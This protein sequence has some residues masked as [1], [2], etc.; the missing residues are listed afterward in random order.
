MAGT[1]ILGEAVT[2]FTADLGGLFGRLDTVVKKLDDLSK[3][4]F[5]VKITADA[6]GIGKSIK[7]I[8]TNIQKLANVITRAQQ[9]VVSGTRNTA[10]TIDSILAGSGNKQLRTVQ[11]V[12]AGINQASDN[13]LSRFVSSAAAASF[14]FIST[15]LRTAAVI[16]TIGYAF[17]SK[18][19]NTITRTMNTAIGNVATVAIDNFSKAVS[20]VWNF[21]DPFERLSEIWNLLSPL[22]SRFAD[23][24]SNA[25]RITL[26]F[27][28]N[29]ALAASHARS[30]GAHLSK[31]VQAR[32][33]LGGVGSDALK[34]AAALERVRQT[35]I[36]LNIA[37][38]A[39]V[40]SAV[41]AGT[42][43]AELSKITLGLYAASEKAA[44]AAGKA[45]EMM[46]LARASGTAQDMAAALQASQEAASA[47]RESF[48]A[49]NQ[50]ATKLATSTVS[51]A[52]RATAFTSIAL[53]L[54]G[55]AS[56]VTFGISA[57]K[58]FM[59]QRANTTLGKTVA[60]IDALF[61]GVFRLIPPLA[62]VLNKISGF[63]SL[64]SGLVLLTTS[65]V[66]SV[67]SVGM[68]FGGAASI[69]TGLL[70]LIQNFSV[71]I[72]L[73]FF[74]VA[75]GFGSGRAQFILF[76]N[77]VRESFSF[78]GR[79]V[80]TLKKLPRNLS[81]A[82]IFKNIYGFVSNIQ[83]RLE[84]IVV[85]LG[86]A[87]GIAQDSAQIT[88]V[89][90]K[91]AVASGKSLREIV[92]VLASANDYLSLFAGAMQRTVVY[93]S[94]QVA[95]AIGNFIT[96][97]FRMAGRL[98]M[99]AGRSIV[100]TFVVRFK[101]AGMGLLKWMQGSLFG[102]ILGTVGAVFRT[103]FAALFSRGA[104]FGKKFSSIWDRQRAVGAGVKAGEEQQ[105]IQKMRSASLQINEL[106]RVR[107]GLLDQEIEKIKNPLLEAQAKVAAAEKEVNS[108]L[109]KGQATRKASIEAAQIAETKAGEA[110][111][112]AEKRRDAAQ[113][114]MTSFEAR[115][116]SSS[117]SKLGNLQL[118]FSESAKGAPAVVDKYMRALSEALASSK[119][120]K[121]KSI[122]IMGT[123]EKA[124][125]TVEQQA[126]LYKQALVDYKSHYDAML[127][128]TN[129]SDREAQ[130][131]KAE[132]ALKHIDEQRVQVQK[133]VFEY[134]SAYIE[135]HKKVDLSD[136]SDRKKAADEALAQIKIKTQSAL[137]S[138][139]DINKATVGSRKDPSM[140]QQAEIKRLAEADI[141]AQK[142][143]VVAKREY[144]DQQ[145]QVVDAW[146]K[147]RD[148]AQAT[149]DVEKKGLE[150]LTKLAAANKAQRDQQ[151]LQLE[152]QK[153]DLTALAQMQ[154]A[155]LKAE[156][157][158]RA[159]VIAE[160]A[161]ELNAL[162]EK[163]TKL[164]GLTVLTTK[165]LSVM[166]Q[167][168]NVASKGMDFEK[169]ITGVG[170]LQS[171]VSDAG[172]AA[173]HLV[174][175]TKDGTI[176][177]VKSIDDALTSLVNKN[178]DFFGARSG[179]KKPLF[180]EYM[181]TAD[182][183]A[184]MGILA[185]SKTTLAGVWE[186]LRRFND[187]AVAIRGIG[188]AFNSDEAIAFSR[189]LEGIPKVMSQVVGSTK[190]FIEQQAE[191]NP[192]SAFAKMASSWNSA[193]KEMRKQ[194][195][196]RA[197]PEALAGTLTPDKVAGWIKDYVKVAGKAFSDPESVTILS[198][199]IVSLI[200]NTF[201]PFLQANSP[202][203]KGPLAKIDEWGYKIGETYTTGTLVGLAT[204][205]EK[206]RTGAGKIAQALAPAQ[207][208]F[209]KMFGL[210]RA[211]RFVGGVE[212]FLDG[213]EHLLR[214]R[215]NTFIKAVAQ[216]FGKEFLDQVK[217]MG[218]KVVQG[219]KWLDKLTGG[220]LKKMAKDWGVA[221]FGIVQVF[222]GL[223]QIVGGLNDV[224]KGIA[225]V[226]DLLIGIVTLDWKRFVGG[227][228]GVLQI[229]P[230]VMKLVIGLS[231]VVIGAG[232]AFFGAAKAVTFWAFRLGKVGLKA[233]ILFAAGLLER[234]PAALRSF[235]D[236][237][238]QVGKSVLFL[239]KVGLKAG[240]L[241]AA[242]LLRGFS[243]VA[244]AFGDVFAAIGKGV[245]FL[246]ERIGRA[247]VAIGHGA[248]V[249]A[250]KIGHG[251]G[252]AFALLKRGVVGVAKGLWTG[253][254]K[255]VGSLFGS[256]KE[257][258]RQE[259]AR[260]AAARFA[261]ASEV[262][263][264]VAQAR[265]V[266]SV[267][268]A[269]KLKDNMDAVVVAMRRIPAAGA[270]MKNVLKQLGSVPVLKQFG[271]LHATLQTAVTKSGPALQQ[272]VFNVYK[273]AFG[274]SALLSAT[275]DMSTAGEN[276]S[277]MLLLGLR[278]GKPEAR[279]AMTELVQV[280]ADHLP[281]S[282]PLIGPLAGMMLT[283]S[284]GRIVNMIAD[285][286]ARQGGFLNKVVKGVLYA[287]FFP[288]F[289]GAGI[290][291]GGVKMAIGLISSFGSA[292]RNVFNNELVRMV[293]QTADAMFD[294]A[295]SASRI[296][297]AVAKYDMF[298][299]AARTVG[300]EGTSLYT[301]FNT[302]QRNMAD[303]ASGALD[304]QAK[305][306]RYGVNV[307]AYKNG[308]LDLV[309]TFMALSQAAKDNGDNQVFMQEAMELTGASYGN[310]QALFRLGGN[311]IREA[312]DQMGLVSNALDDEAVRKAEEFR[313]NTARITEAWEGVKREI[314]NVVMPALNKFFEKAL[315]WWASFKDE[316][317][318]AVGLVWQIIEILFTAIFEKLGQWLASSSQATNDLI[319]MLEVLFRSGLRLTQVVF[320]EI[321]K[322][323][324]VLLSSLSD[325]LA[326]WLR[327]LWQRLTQVWFRQLYAW[328]MQTASD[329]AGEFF[330]GVT[331]RIRFW[332]QNAQFDMDR[333]WVYIKSGIYGVIDTLMLLTAPITKVLEWM[334]LI[335]DGGTSLS[336]APEFDSGF[337]LRQITSD[338]LNSA[339]YD[340][341]FRRI[342]GSYARHAQ[343]TIDELEENAA[344][345]VTVLDREYGEAMDHIV[346]N[347]QRVMTEVGDAVGDAAGVII[348]EIGTTLR[349][350]G[351][352]IG[353]NIDY[354][355]ISASMARLRE[356]IFQAVSFAD[357][358]LAVHTLEEL[359]ERYDAL[360]EEMESYAGQ[361]SRFT[362]MFLDINNRIREMRTSVNDLLGRDTFNV[363]G[364][365]SDLASRVAEVRQKITAMTDEADQLAS[366]A[367]R[368]RSET[369]APFDVKHTVVRAQA[370]GFIAEQKLL[371]S[372]KR[373]ELALAERE[374]RL[375]S[376]LIEQQRE[377]Y[378]AQLASRKAFEEEQATALERTLSGMEAEALAARNAAVAGELEYQEQMLARYGQTPGFLPP[379]WQEQ[380][381]TMLRENLEAMTAEAQA[382]RDEVARQA[383][384]GTAQFVEGWFTPALDVLHEQITA[385]EQLVQL[386]WTRLGEIAVI[387]EETAEATRGLTAT[388]ANAQA[389]RARYFA[390]AQAEALLLQNKADAVKAA[391]AAM[392]S[393]LDRVEV[394]S[395]EMALAENVVRLFGSVE[396]PAKD[397][398]QRYMDALGRS[399]D[400]EM[401]TANLR[402][403]FANA[404]GDPATLS[405]IVDRL[406]PILQTFAAEVGEGW[407]EGII[408]GLRRGETAS[409]E[410]FVSW[411]ARFLA[412]ARQ[413]QQEVEVRESQ[414]RIL[415]SRAEDV[416]QRLEV[417][418]S[419]TGTPDF[420]LMQR[421]H[422][423]S[424]LTEINRLRRES[425][426]IQIEQAEADI[427][428][429]F[430]KYRDALSAKI[431][432]FNASLKELTARPL[433]P[434]NEKAIIE[435]EAKIATLQSELD[436]LDG[437]EI[438][439]KREIAIKI[440]Y[441]ADNELRESWLE[442]AGAISN[443]TGEALK[444]G[445]EIAWTGENKL[446]GLTK[447]F[448]TALRDSL[449][450]NFI[451]NLTQT[452]ETQLTKAFASIFK[453]ADSMW[454]QIATLGLTLVTTL[455]VGADEAIEA[456]RD[457]VEDL[458]ESSEQVRG[459]I[460]GDTTVA[461]KEVGDNLRDALQ[462]TNG[463]L[464]DIR[465]GVYAM[466][467]QRGV[468][469]AAAGAST[470]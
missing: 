197:I 220:L 464:R 347:A 60:L 142:R 105:N 125:A 91:A 379:D 129:V 420:T 399:I 144:I 334:G 78:V 203:K 28:N 215:Y 321:L 13:V 393:S 242:G 350:L 459:V 410:E 290:L 71:K 434:E 365:L 9:D 70:P 415:E 462:P 465:D 92:P 149:R 317:Y 103:G 448:G 265:M 411:Y 340:Q 344:Q 86:R 467:R 222:K 346:N 165:T 460:S 173:L 282:P 263:A 140:V 189:V 295:I 442:F 141:A 396:G 305:M 228:R 80:E 51:F 83:T 272:A 5:S 244:R 397:F 158:T 401:N 166:A 94:T 151:V 191:A 440:R 378:S 155:V 336:V 382:A 106:L 224:R 186:N 223:G 100:N 69:L 329:N 351:A 337:A 20:S 48:A 377:E 456:S 438:T 357:S 163:G 395:K 284:G 443:A 250:K 375:R 414:R 318:E 406:Q 287:A 148:A 162:T 79:L 266:A 259:A 294:V 193:S 273:R 345:A 384:E 267:A 286:V 298:A 451:N 179:P 463:I 207:E 301:V 214:G 26:G 470:V 225:S 449:T 188:K 146:T 248:V 117:L 75:A 8:D 325:L 43:L 419:P 64:G 96:L 280:L 253:A 289:G 97:P 116:K 453:S 458:V 98:A 363:S 269:K 53:A 277:K 11:K 240:S 123:V 160:E 182:I 435:L 323:G 268:A 233:G 436:I 409:I 241:F 194:V 164:K 195:L 327:N 73:L 313:V 322:L 196:G 10:K 332:I 84:E 81:I 169:I 425:A 199:H 52:A 389:A 270:P 430:D 312:M 302:L 99:N 246:S 145:Q 454:G 349:E 417:A 444:K 50:A 202:P 394:L 156:M 157:G 392:A 234:F 16:T 200:D 279:K 118:V 390:N 101:G 21:V 112:A 90:D 386:E 213:F 128:A 154:Q 104:S 77:N 274:K 187:I 237:F 445:L 178:Q 236:G 126:S 405:G 6:S 299:K 421:L 113:A 138:V 110:A 219:F 368:R 206:I 247:F 388:E 385:Y 54:H 376:K 416:A 152:K 4:T 108:L 362:A 324:G 372:Q 95:H 310:L 12:Q 255:L 35:T 387:T 139:R 367:E 211:E 47:L 437:R 135:A 293:K 38:G 210:G 201:V 352:A 261:A 433:T 452:L 15:A 424:R 55:V 137:D 14:S 304:M 319:K 297:V 339:T 33:V 227:L 361:H 170:Q 446:K 161:A 391:V 468:Q 303:A 431:I 34:A 281:Q 243:R 398:A 369:V 127:A 107:L 271:N 58:A 258:N 359:A 85:L 275:A 218:E 82:N 17:S 89:V 278:K 114:A 441:E 404:L 111:I 342:R 245:I 7:N 181:K 61:L 238:V 171:R 315:T 3:R 93:L 44:L 300:V 119:L 231:R 132:N 423:A 330:D 283:L 40:R 76:I 232:V 260:A 2:Q 413:Q 39:Y 469:V 370:E 461:L 226:P 133:A 159:R 374:V 88:S 46:N 455:L 184:F 109:K 373:D 62:L 72:R 402:S 209:D 74:R 19:V 68:V 343:V 426:E 175:R 466:N 432:K 65:L 131:A 383:A 36:N 264:K 360:A 408:E 124:R 208:K 371:L 23:N 252:S 407:N 429:R 428:E 180:V 1:Y 355:T 120:G 221:V 326:P 25:A 316:A 447:A 229:I 59:L 27:S 296:D 257:K 254:G 291:I 42:P 24:M 168:R 333:L 153:A 335:E 307:E 364:A 358:P 56:A 130:K 348:T 338:Q 427:D 235:R 292:I 353:L 31:V 403:D 217:W 311:D 256:D 41:A 331:A 87:T 49:V 400:D 18:F 356:L 412:R 37:I 167:L 439:A 380:R 45:S 134:Q 66:A 183:E 457:A 354:E 63:I 102:R 308:T 29:T 309:D 177:A 22:F 285:G 147:E 57:F 341:I 212:I 143:I 150:E 185:K 204:G 216:A 262:W 172:D 115:F 30:L 314:V 422:G 366:R 328:I 230:G 381:D 276:M 320:G 136:S 190:A 198:N 32:Y 249:A 174:R 192:S 239:G 288:L 176:E 205:A 121:G 418:E 450:D 122:E 306:E 251:F 67:S